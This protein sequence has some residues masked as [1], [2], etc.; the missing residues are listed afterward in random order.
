MS[1]LIIDNYDSYTFNLYQQVARVTGCPPLVFKNDEITI[2]EIKALG[3]TNI[4]ISPGPGHPGNLKDFGICG[5]VLLELKTP[6]L[7]VCL[8]HQGIAHFYGGSVG[9]AAEVRH[10]R[11]SKVRHNDVGLFRGIPQEFGV[12]RYH[13]LVVTDP[14]PECLE[15]I[16]WTD[17]VVMGLRHKE[18]PL[19]GV[20]FHPES[21]CT[22]YGDQMVRNFFDIYR[23]AGRRDE[24]ADAGG[25]DCYTR[26]N[27]EPR[28]PT[29][30]TGV[31]VHH[32]C[33]D[34][35]VDPE[36][37]FASLYAGKKHSFWLD[38]SKAARGLAR[39]SFMG[40]ADGPDSYVV[41]YNVEGQLLTIESGGE[42]RCQREPIFDYLQRELAANAC[43]AEGLPFDFNCGFVGYFGYE[44]KAECGGKLAHASE[45]PDAYFLF[46]D[47]ILAFD[48]EERAIYLLTLDRGGRARQCEEWFDWVERLLRSLP[49]LPPVRR[50]KSEDV[51]FS[52]SRSYERYM[53]DI[54]VCLRNIRAGESYEICLTNKI[55]TAP[56]EHPFDVYRVLRGI[57]P[58]PYAA[59]LKFDE[60]AIL[61][62]S[63][64]QFLK[65]GADRSVSAKPIKGTMARCPDPEQDEKL[66][67]GLA[68]DEK[69]RSEN[70]MIV[71]L[72]R[73]D[74]G[75]V[76]E[77]GTVV[78]PVLMGVES[79]ATVHQLVSTICGRLRGDVSAIECIR[80]AFPGGSMTGAPKIR[81]MEILDEIEGEARGIYS[82]AIGFLGL[83]GSSELNIVIR[84]V[85]TTH[86]ETSIGVG[87]AVVALSDPR[88]E[89][90]E[91]LLKARALIRA[92]VT[93]EKG[94]F[95]EDYY[96]VVG[97][98]K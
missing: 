48:H 19:W 59:F 81:T 43:R 62:S 85:V 58:A 83:N 21:I 29:D 54:D 53:S 92:I 67:R 23:D 6:L 2:D 8:G 40:A 41:R 89:F 66:R 65:I 61:S 46:A 97:L 20:Q 56:L 87:G 57:N 70:L 96:R 25:P 3:I 42:V 47:R 15:V 63:P 44:L 34:F 27:D 74:L 64:E 77:I 98:E 11:I 28:T 84:T 16:A 91:M 80:A 31:K 4:I 68:E 12:V 1:V 38:T 94:D 69:N 36:A 78:V 13:S 39:Y 55:T 5:R 73:N 9:P 26:R 51:T 76:C 24:V 95:S 22:E 72:L 18:L 93:A 35:Y 86:S 71:D 10:G 50:Q 7:G 14:L 30:S 88:S 82:G 52:L 37:V 45:R 32:R 75:K 79:Y 49:A 17:D 60:L 33:L 90:E